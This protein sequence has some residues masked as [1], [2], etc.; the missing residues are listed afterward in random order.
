M[1]P[2]DLSHYH[3]NK[4]HLFRRRCWQVVNRLLFPLLPS[5]AR[6]LLLRLFGARI[7][8]SLIY[9]SVNVFAPWN[10]EVGDYSCIGPRVNLYN[11]AWV[12]IGD[13]AVLSQDVFVCTASHDTSSVNMA[14]V[15]KSITIGN[16]CWIAARAVLL[17]GVTLG[18]YAVAGLGAVVAKPVQEYG[19]VVGNPAK[20]VKIRKIKI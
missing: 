10:L 20:V 16:G 19:I 8:K 12:R 4:P 13:N 5:F 9:R 7:G 15:T 14:L 3:E 1:C 11:K 17:P 2:V 6:C 18:D